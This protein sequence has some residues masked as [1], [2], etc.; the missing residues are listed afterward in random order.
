M[1]LWG[2]YSRLYRILP[3]ALRW[4]WLSLVALSLL[5]SVLEMV[6]ALIV[7]GLINV[8]S[9]PDSL[10]KLPVI[11]A[12]LT[13]LH[14]DWGDRLIVLIAFG[15]AVFFVFKNVVAFLQ[16]WMQDKCAADTVLAMATRL[17]GRY[18]AMP[19]L[20]MLG[21]NSAEILRNVERSVDFASRTML[22]SAVVVLTESFVVLG[23]LLVLLISEPLVTVITAGICALVMLVA[24]KLTQR[25]FAAWGARTMELY[26]LCTQD[27]QQALGALKEA[28]VLGREGAFLAAFRRS[29]ME[30]VEVQRKVATYGHA[31]RLTIETLMVVA[32]VLIIAAVVGQNRATVEIMPVIGLFAYTGFRVMPSVNRIIMQLN[33][34]RTSSASIDHI[35]DDFCQEMGAEAA[36]TSTAAPR[37]SFRRTICVDTVRFRYDGADKSVLDGLSLEIPHGASVGLVGSTGSGKSTLV[38][39]LLGLIPPEGGRILV[40]GVDIAENLG[41]WQRHIGYV[42]QSIFL[43]DDTIRRNIALGVEPK[44]I[45]EQALRRAAAM[46]QV[47]DFIEAQPQGFDTLVGENGVRLSGG[48]RQRLGVARALYHQ[49]DVLVFDEATSALDNQTESLLAQDLARLSGSK[50]LIMVA[51]RLSTLRDCDRIY[52][53]RAGQVVAAGTFAQ[54]LSDC[55]EFRDLARAGMIED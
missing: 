11:G 49:P 33:N 21:R 4:R 37:L 44:D 50:T 7:F 29:K 48:Q 42:P 34:M 24:L 25:H 32:M 51:H 35:Y 5:T 30:H 54:L 19:H 38:D 40:D 12:A 15:A 2:R 17:L 6:G 20:S 26:R 45:D 46:A 39:I 52:L 28:R 27:I 43:A 31:P 1:N 41:D 9:N 8:V 53:L 10:G 16:I 3:A 14:Q 18:L 13:G 22:L 47:L 36:V 55:D 23:L